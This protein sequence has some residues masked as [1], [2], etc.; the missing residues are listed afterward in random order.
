MEPLSLFTDWYNDWLMTDPGEPSAM[1]LS[2]A[3]KDGIISSRVVLLKNFDEKG[4][5]F[6]SNYKSRKGRQIASNHRAALLFWWQPLGR[7]VR[8]EG[9]VRKVS[10]EISEQYF[11][12]RPRENQISSWA[13]DQSRVIPDRNY[14][15]NRY[16]YYSR[17]FTGRDIDLPPNCGGYQVIPDRFEFWTEGE[18]RLHDRIIF[19]LQQNRW[20]MKR[21]AP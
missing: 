21:L 7:Q 4:F 6:Y 15:N 18:H 3:G 5:F 12:T 14:L 8:I 17:I 20:K 2:T 9:S 13:S 1:V 19:S 10:R 11:R 16:D